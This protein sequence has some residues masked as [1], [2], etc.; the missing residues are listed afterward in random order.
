MT[1]PAIPTD[2]GI[3]R[4]ATKASLY[5]GVIL[6]MPSR[7][8]TSN[9]VGWKSAVSLFAMSKRTLSKTSGPSPVTYTRRSARAKLLH[10]ALY[11][12]LVLQWIG[13]DKLPTQYTLQS[14]TAQT[15]ALDRYHKL[16]HHVQ[17]ICGR[18]MGPVDHLQTKIVISSLRNP[19]QE[20]F[21]N[22]LNL[23]DQRKRNPICQR[24]DTNPFPSSEVAWN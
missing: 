6:S 12:K 14:L 19:R 23:S 2:C 22:L 4:D 18:K 9:K 7:V 16:S 20:I 13:F 24:Y 10:S 5:T 15:I 8:P 17:R 11:K 21:S 3:I 1:H